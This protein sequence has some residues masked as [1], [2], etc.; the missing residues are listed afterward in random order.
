MNGHD[1][2]DQL[3]KLRGQEEREHSLEAYANAVRTYQDAVLALQDL[4]LEQPAVHG[5]VLERLEAAKQEVN[6][7][8]SSFQRRLS[9]A[10]GVSLWGRVR[11]WG[12]RHVFRVSSR[13]FLHW[14]AQFLREDS[15]GFQSF[16]AFTKIEPVCAVAR[17]LGADYNAFKFLFFFNPFLRT[18]EQLFAYASAPVV[19]GNNKAPYFTVWLALQVMDDWHVNPTYGPL[20]IVCAGHEH[21]VV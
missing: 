17:D 5:S 1:Y 21:D 11:G 12:G 2:Q 9:A 10:G 16:V 8:R 3:A 20:G 18:R 4:K 6:Y 14:I 7:Y 15:G 19:S 13:R